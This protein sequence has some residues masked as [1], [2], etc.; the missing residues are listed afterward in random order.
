[1]PEDRTHLVGQR[2]VA[3]PRDRDRNADPHRKVCRYQ[4]G[5]TTWASSVDYAV[6][7]ADGWEAWQDFRLSLRGMSPADKVKR[8][9]W[10]LRTHD[11]EWD[12]YR[13]LNYARSQRATWK[14]T[15]EMATISRQLAP[16]VKGERT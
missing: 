14:S 8:L 1:M 15:P 12:I 16:M 4:K 10:W 7:H 6:Y 5:S 13:V 3:S 11:S 2:G 9:R